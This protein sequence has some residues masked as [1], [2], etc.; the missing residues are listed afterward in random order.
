MGCGCRFPARACPQAIGRSVKRVERLLFIRTDRMG[1]V[2]MNL[3]AIRLWR[4]AYPKAWI[5]LMA[6]QSVADLFKGHPDLDEVLAVDS[7][8]FGDLFYGFKLAGLL[9]RARFDAAVV[10]NPM[11]FLHAL[12]FFS[13]IPERIGV[14]RKWHFFL[15]EK[16]PPARSG[17]EI[18]RNLALTRSYSG[19]RLWDGVIE[20]SRDEALLKRAE[21]SVKSL[22]AGRPVLALHAGTS[23]PRKLWPEERFAEVCRLASADGFAIALVGGDQEKERSARIVV[24]AGS[25]IMDLTGRLTLRE[26]AAFFMLGDVK[27]LVSADSGP[28]HVAWM[29]G[30]PVVA[31]YAK[32]VEGC[33]PARWG[34][35]DGGVSETLY[36]PMRDIGAEEVYGHL[37]RVAAKKKAVL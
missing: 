22:S 24:A 6:D 4:Q 3:P 11:K 18:E 35:R 8:R 37:R 10:S 36:R 17:H 13:G 5:T 34:P 19:G 12:L 33:D 28:V 14:A 2:L 25:P 26:L 27:A 9:R 31:L 16:I 15:T 1:D 29:A 20:L 23:N 21:G 7:G 30:T 32:D